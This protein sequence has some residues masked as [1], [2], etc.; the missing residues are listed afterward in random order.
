MG[1][2]TRKSPTEAIRDSGS[3][4]VELKRTLGPYS[5]V[6]FGV[7]AI[8][9]AGIFSITGIAAAEYA[10]PAILISFLIAAAGCAFSALCYSELAGV[11]PV[12]GSAYTYAYVTMGEIFAWIIGWDLILEYTV[13]AS[14]VAISW[15]GYLHSFL[16][17]FGIS[18]PMSIR[19]SPWSSYVAT[20][21][22]IVRGMVNL[23]AVAIVVA[24]SLILMRGIRES[25]FLNSIFVVIKLSIII[26]FIGVGTQ[27]IDMENYV[28]FIPENTGVFGEYG[29]SGI[30]RASGMVFFA[31]IGFDCISTTTQE[32][33][34]P[35]RNMPIGILGALVIC[36]VLYI[37]F[38]AVLV[39][40]VPYAELSVDAPVAL[41][42]DRTPYPWLAEMVKL[43]ILAGFT[44]V[45]LVLLLGQS[46]IFY[47]MSKDGLL[48]PIF[49]VLH[50]RW[51]TP[52]RSNI[53][54]MIFTSLFS[55]FMPLSAVGNMTSIG[56]LFAFIIVCASVL[57]LRRTH[58]EYPRAFKTPWVPAVPLLGIGTCSIMMLSLD[59]ETWVRLL[60]W[61]VLGGIFYFVYGR[62]RS[63]KKIGV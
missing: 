43:A 22:S 3:S 11:I 33:V 29:W 49:S 46:R 31:Y 15:S 53:I 52:W 44:S 24:A 50:P 54:L 17:D 61:L 37:A 62:Y 55:A 41:A 26:I 45:M 5:L 19:A 1:M 58:P 21:G 51:Q 39:G 30:L 28:P 9:G 7:G 35:Q 60:V 59:G 63:D 48:P 25:S 32:T 27:Y 36:T 57:I 23:P 20:D 38:A 8:V 47:A 34:D 56:T 40:I 16:S 10:G 18:L 6:M 42:I 4:T 2:L 13:G 14:A 12:S